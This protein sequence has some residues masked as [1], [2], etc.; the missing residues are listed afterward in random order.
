VNSSSGSQQGDS[1]MTNTNVPDSSGA[2]R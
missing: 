1:A 2:Q